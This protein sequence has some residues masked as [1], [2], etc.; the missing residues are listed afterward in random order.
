M[1]S[2]N[3][4]SRSIRGQGSRTTGGSRLF[5]VDSGISSCSGG[6][7]WHRGGFPGTATESSVD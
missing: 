1:S 4:S 3:G 2:L 6:N 5:L 7:T